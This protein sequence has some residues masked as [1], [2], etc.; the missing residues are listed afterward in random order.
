MP[1]FF[2]GGVIH[3]IVTTTNGLERQHEDLKHNY[4]TD[5]S[6]GLLADLV[7]AVVTQFVPQSKRRYYQRNVH[8]LCVIRAYNA[9]ILVFLHNRP[10]KFMLVTLL[11]IY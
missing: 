9:A 11:A 1:A 3:S 7:S 8:A 6:N 2:G 5:S 4:L 10:P